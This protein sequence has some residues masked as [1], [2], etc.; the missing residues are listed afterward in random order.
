MTTGRARKHLS[1]APAPA[2][3]DAWRGDLVI[4]K[5]GECRATPHN[6]SLVLDNDPEMTGL[7]RLDEFAG[8]IVLS[9]DPP[10][11]GGV[12]REFTEQDAFE[13]AAWLGRPDTYSMACK[14]AQVAEAVEAVA[15]RHRFHA[16]RDYLDSLEHDGEERIARLFTT[17][18]GAEHCDYLEGV[19]AV[20]MLG[21]VARIYE[22]GC[23]V[24]HMLVLE[25]KQGGGKTS[26]VRALFGGDEWYV[27]AQ[28]SPADKD[29]YQ[30]IVGKWVAEI[31]EMTSFSK[32]DYNKVK[33][34]LS[35]QADTYRPS[36]GRYSR[37]FK[38]QCIFVGTTNEDA[39]QRDP[40]GGRRYLPVRVSAVDV[41]AVT[42][43]RDQL[44][45][46]AVMRYQ[47]GDSWWNAPANAEDEQDDRYCDDPW[48]EAV[49]RWILGHA[50]D[51]DYDAIDMRARDGEGRVI[52]CS[53]AE[54]LAN[55]LHLEVEKHDLR[56]QQRVGVIMS[57]LG[58]KKYRRDRGKDIKVGRVWYWY[59]PS[60]WR[61]PNA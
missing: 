59:A 13:L 27:D 19:A 49:V 15:R 18:F 7:F 12:S 31:G 16:V 22:P 61:W 37:T 60:D 40:T 11:S 21:A 36:Y 1:I 20:F 35:A 54:V 4:S 51:R 8:R 58:W 34:T 55:A 17:Y 44:W 3:E 25:G 29:F 5:A 10:W 53:V 52:E 2:P 42:R 48:A 30:D 32:A 14:A 9:R 45:A 41:V 43:D 24:D 47:R 46:E 26:A 57:R 6:I 38:R 56:P 50:K 28:R 33:Q 39:W 23:K